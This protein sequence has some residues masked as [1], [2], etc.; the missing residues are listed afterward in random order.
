MY[1]LTECKRASYLPPDQID[2][3]TSSIGR[4]M[5]NS[6]LYLVDDAGEPIEG[7]GE[8]ELIVRG[9]NVMPV[10]LRQPEA[11]ARTLRARQPPDTNVTFTRYTFRRNHQELS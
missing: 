4:G 11:T 2:T 7:Q 6:E 3:R 8:G 10:N 5:P 9:S 1:G